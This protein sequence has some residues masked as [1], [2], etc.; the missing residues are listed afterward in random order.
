MNK[1]GQIE[2]LGLAILVIILG[3]ILVLALG[4]SVNFSDNKEDLRAGLVANSL[5]NS[6]I[7]QQNVKRLMHECYVEFKKN[8]SNCQDLE[9]ELNKIMLLSVNKKFQITLNS[10]S[11][12]FFKTG[13]CLRGVQSTPYRFKEQGETLTT[14]LKLC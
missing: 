14:V 9:K 13:N 7:K 4:F 2:I 6:I 3:V 1:K 10:N 12:D 8:K 5:L 11:V